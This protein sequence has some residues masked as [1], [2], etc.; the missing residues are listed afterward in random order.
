MRAAIVLACA[1]V[2]VTP[3]QASS[4]PA[5]VAK[6]TSLSSDLAWSRF[7]RAIAVDYNRPID[8]ATSSIHVFDG[9]GAPVTDAVIDTVHVWREWD[10][11]SR[12][13]VDATIF[14]FVLLREAGFCGGRAAPALTE[15][16]GPYTATFSAR[17]VGQ[18]EGTP[19]TVTTYRFR[20]DAASPEPPVLEVSG[21]TPLPAITPSGC[22]PSFQWICDGTYPRDPVP[23]QVAVV[24]PG[25]RAHL[26]GRAT[27][28]PNRDGH[29]DRVSG[30]AMVRLH[31]YAGAW[32]RTGGFGIV[33]VSVTAG[34]RTSLAMT[35]TIACDAGRCPPDTLFE[36][37]P[38]LPRGYWAIRAEAVDLAGNRS[39]MS[40]QIGLLV[41]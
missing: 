21:G 36:A 4:T 22:D 31:V 39:E 24:A 17:A 41:A 35:I 11:C 38:E 12:Q 29:A 3:A 32:I 8:V 27:D 2:G 20:I 16:L 6:T 13:E 15:D 5:P 28:A 40:G 26:T 1:L 34:E 10:A 33:P 19:A 23:T 30:I 7:D 14:S 18:D 9:T 25:A 37:T